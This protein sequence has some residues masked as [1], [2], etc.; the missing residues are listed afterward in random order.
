MIRISLATLLL[1]VAC[2]V[3]I[4]QQPVSTTAD[5]EAA[6]R[7]AIGSY[8]EAY[9]RADAQAVAAHWGGNGRVDEPQWRDLCGPRGDRESDGQSLRRKQ[10][11]EDRGP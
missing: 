6:I 1:A 8:V 5:D 10:E 3:A 7:A 11:Y 9:N 4:A 2:S